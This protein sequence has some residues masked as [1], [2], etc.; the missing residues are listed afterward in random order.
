MS[1]SKLGGSQVSEMSSALPPSVSFSSLDRV[2]LC[3]KGRSF[4]VVF[5]VSRESVLTST[6][7]TVQVSQYVE[8]S[9]SLILVSK[10]YLSDHFKSFNSVSL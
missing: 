3:W 9:S 10:P 1:A 6:D 7:M 4:V 8:M 5:R 2:V